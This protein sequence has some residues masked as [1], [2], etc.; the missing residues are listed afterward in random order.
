MPNFSGQQ[1]FGLRNLN[2]V[3][4]TYHTLLSDSK[5]PFPSRVDRGVA[6]RQSGSEFLQKNYRNFCKM[7]SSLRFFTETSL[8]FVNS[9]LI[10]VLQHS[11]AILQA[12]IQPGATSYFL[13]WSYCHLFLTLCFCR[14]FLHPSKK[15]RSLSN[16]ILFR[17]VLHLPEIFLS[18]PLFQ[19]PFDILVWCVK[20][21]P[22]ETW[23]YFLAEESFSQD[24]SFLRLKF[25]CRCITSEFGVS[26]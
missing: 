11:K 2:F 26:K 8:K 23:R 13:S 25:D 6:S 20:R 10:S 9:L 14:S 16:V 7:F 1:G 19:S 21:N 18:T 22:S 17:R 15:V 12:R 4:F 24:G 5:V 3:L